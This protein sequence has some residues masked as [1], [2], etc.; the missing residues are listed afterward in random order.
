[1]SN[2]SFSI[3]SPD[4]G[5]VSDVHDRLLIEVGKTHV[6]CI[7]T[8]DHKKSISAFELFHFNENEAADF[9]KLF[10]RLSAESE[11]L[12]KSYPAT[13]VFINNESSLLVPVFKFNTEIA[14]DYF[15][16]IF[17]EDPGSAVHFDHLPIEPGMMNVY[18]VAENLIGFLQDNFQKVS[19]RHTYSNIIKTIVSDISAYPAECIYIQFYNTFLIVSVAKDEK[20]QLIQSFTYQTPED[21]LYH[22]LNIA[23]RFELNRERVILEIS[24]MIDLHFTLYRDLITYFKHVEVQN[25]HTVKLMLDIKEYPLHY[26]TPFF[27]LAI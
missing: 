11:L 2:K 1:M 10:A 22:L 24:G 12:D 4:S 5:K 14:A 20:L 8:N 7:N 16:V 17:G 27:N 15:N 18:R 23:E 25:V 3:Y 19:F 13:Q 26:F 6:A 21:I 9:S